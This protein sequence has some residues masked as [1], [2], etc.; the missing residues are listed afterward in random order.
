MPKPLMLY[1]SVRMGLRPAQCLVCAEALAVHLAV[2]FR[3]MQDSAAA[4]HG[5]A[6]LLCLRIYL[7]A[8][9]HASAAKTA[10]AFASLKRHTH[11]T[12][13]C[14]SCSSAAAAVLLV[15]SLRWACDMALDEPVLRQGN[16]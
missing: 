14:R 9:G 10:A 5:C 15:A 11:S 3:C 16:A 12:M 8:Q 7:Q 13:L 4:Q 1:R 2:M 6:F